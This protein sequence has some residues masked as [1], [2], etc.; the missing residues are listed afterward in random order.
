V[1]GLRP[2]VSR[3]SVLDPVHLLPILVVCGD[4]RGSSHYW[5][6]PRVLQDERHDLLPEVDQDDLLI[7]KRRATPAE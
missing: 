6:P 4:H 1:A 7:S 5:P 2:H 3:G